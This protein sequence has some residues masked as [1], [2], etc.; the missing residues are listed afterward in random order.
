ML[1]LVARSAQPLNDEWLG[2]IM[3][4]GVD[5]SACA[6]SFTKEWTDQ[7]S[8]R[9]SGCDRGHRARTLPMR[10]PILALLPV[11][12]KAIARVVI[13]GVRE[14]PSRVFEWAHA[15]TSYGSGRLRCAL[16][17]FAP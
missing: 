12:M 14:T 16:H 13:A 11:D 8:G 1:S 5:R 2:V 6:A 15:G 10:R 9:E 3:M 17:D 7:Q 4:M